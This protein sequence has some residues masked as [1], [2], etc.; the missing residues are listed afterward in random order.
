MM[1]NVMTDTEWAPDA[2]M[3]SR[4][5]NVLRLTDGR[6]MVL[7]HPHDTSKVPCLAPGE[8]VRLIPTGI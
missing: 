8:R 5:R 7:R 3:V 6:E 4:G 2:E 1:A